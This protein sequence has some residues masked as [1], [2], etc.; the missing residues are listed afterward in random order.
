MSSRALPTRV[1]EDNT[2][3]MARSGGMEQPVVRLRRLRRTPALRALVR[4]HRLSVDDLILPLFV[5]DPGEES[6]E[7]ESM[8]GVFRE[9]VEF[10]AARAER[11]FEAGIRAVILF[12]IPSTKD[13][14]ASMAYA[15][16]GVIQCATRALRDRCPDL[17]VIT[18]TC[19]CE[20][21]DHGHCGLLD[22]RME[23]DNDATLRVLAQIA[24]SQAESGADLV[25]PSGMMDGQVAAIRSAL[26]S[27]GHESVGI[28]AY[29]AKY[30]S[31]F[32]GPFRD[33]AQGAPAFG[34]RRGHQ[35]DPANGGEAV[36]EAALDIGEGADLI[37]VK[38]AL[39][40]LD[41]VRRLREAFAGV[42][43]VAYNVSGEYAVVKAGARAGWIDEPSVVLETLTAMK[44][45]GADLII[46]YHASDVAS[47]LRDPS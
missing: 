31:A 33:A 19:M 5:S 6:V 45:A 14:D 46:T 11:A 13:A 15:A 29:S 42:P 43:I 4:E 25:A 18:D 21:T 30:A 10:T 16:E 2:E 7:I 22:A 17:V 27:A 24:V 12:G 28:L 35:M 9:N 34:D 47:W 32:Y 3:S 41:V 20:Y 44:R 38:P 37:M 26:D 8:P 36:R 1:K 40:Y 23:V 39:A